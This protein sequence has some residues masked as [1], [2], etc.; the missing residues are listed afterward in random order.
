MIFVLAV[1][2][3]WVASYL[4]TWLAGRIIEPSTLG[5]IRLL[6]EEYYEVVSKAYAGAP[7]MFLIML[8]TIIE[9]W[10]TCD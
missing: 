9:L 5:T 4:P 1:F 7:E 6:I 8:L 3:R 10:V 2:K